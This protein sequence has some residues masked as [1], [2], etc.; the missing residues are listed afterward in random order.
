MVD[1][2]KKLLEELILQQR[3]TLLREGKRVIPTLIEEDLL[4]PNDFLELEESPTFR[5]EEGIL[6]GFLSFKAAIN[7]LERE[8]FSQSLQAPL[9][10]E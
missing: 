9:Q 1:E 10:N 6:A 4:Q 3:K 7:A 5:Y 8:S 2:I